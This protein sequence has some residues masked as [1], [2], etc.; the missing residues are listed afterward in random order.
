MQC[1]RALATQSDW[2][3][4]VLSESPLEVNFDFTGLVRILKS[5]RDVDFSGTM[6]VIAEDLVSAVHDEFDTAGHGKWAPLAES[7]IANRRHGGGGGDALVLQD[8]GRLYASIQP[9]SG[10]DY[11]KASTDV[12]YAIYHVS[13]EA[14]HKIPLRDFFD[15]PEE[16]YEHAQDTIVK[17]W[18]DG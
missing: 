10:A 12:S 15:L 9:D 13:K 16:V 3:R 17:K 8:T 4:W 7:T 14:R 2:P 11:A 6:A 18:L 5:K 1:V